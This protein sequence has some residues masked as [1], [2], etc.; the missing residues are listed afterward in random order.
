VIRPRVFLA[1]DHPDFLKLE[2]AFLQ[3]H[4]ELIGTAADGASLVS[5]VLRL[6]PDVVVADITMPIMTGIDAV[7][8]LVQSGCTA[9]FVFLTIHASEEYVQACLEQGARGFVTKSRMKAHLIPAINA[10]LDGRP[11]VASS[12]TI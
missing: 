6:S 1:D 4:F 11:Y 3:P 12:S 2:M 7:H 8:K 9:K 5:E 10:V